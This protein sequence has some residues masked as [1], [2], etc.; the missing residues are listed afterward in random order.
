LSLN[1]FTDKTEETVSLGDNYFDRC[2]NL[3]NGLYDHAFDMLRLRSLAAI[4]LLRI[5]LWRL[6]NSA[7]RRCRSSYIARGVP[8]LT[9]AALRKLIIDGAYTKDVSGGRSI[10][11]LNEAR[12]FELARGAQR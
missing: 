9:T 4:C 3:F 1:L 6:L 12:S 8:Q 5:R 2:W 11:L 10:R 7:R